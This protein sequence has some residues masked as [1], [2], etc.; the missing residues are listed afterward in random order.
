MVVLGVT[1]GIASGKS[2]VGRLLQARGAL[3]ID[4][5]QVARELLAP[6]GR[7]SEQ[8][9]EAF[10]GGVRRPDGSVDRAAVARIIFGDPKARERLNRITHPPILA[11]IE[12]RIQQLRRSPAPPSVV[13]VILPLLFEAGAEGLVEKTLVVTADEPEQIRRLRQR[14]GLTEAEAR[15]RIAAQMAIEEKIRRADWVLDTTRGE[16]ATEVA[17]DAMWRGLAG[18]GP[19]TATF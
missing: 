18:S 15:Q 8:V 6:G 2:T 16:A 12:K 3:I 1:G 4:A 7:L 11:E 19:A 9:I 13:A 14:D 10:G 5:D 17:V